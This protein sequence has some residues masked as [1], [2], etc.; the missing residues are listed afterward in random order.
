MGEVLIL[1]V[2]VGTLVVGLSVGIPVGFIETLGTLVGLDVGM[3][4]SVGDV[5]TVGPLDKVG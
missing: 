5:L 4:L 3:V 2:D 1:G